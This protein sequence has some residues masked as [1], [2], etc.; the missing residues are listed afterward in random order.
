MALYIIK[1]DVSL[2]LGISS[3][4]LPRGSIISVVQLDKVHNKVLI[5]VGPY[6]CDWILESWLEKYCEVVG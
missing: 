4:I 6:C 1:E 3:F 5:E 2:I